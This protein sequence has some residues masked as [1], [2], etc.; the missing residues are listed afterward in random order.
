MW[1]P[2]SLSVVLCEMGTM[3]PNSQGCR[4][5]FWKRYVS[6]GASR[7][8]RVQGPAGVW[9]GVQGRGQG[10]RDAGPWRSVL[11]VYPEG[12]GESWTV[13]VRVLLLT[14]GWRWGEGAMGGILRWRRS[15]RVQGVES[16]SWWWGPRSPTS[17]G[18]WGLSRYT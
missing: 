2:W 11:K 8:G 14:R 15:Y 7:D 6:M 5:M 4:G 13:Q 10:V 18:L 12:T 1:L 17:R 9:S 16:A 3:P